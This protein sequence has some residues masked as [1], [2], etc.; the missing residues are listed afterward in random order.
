MLTINKHIKIQDDRLVGG[1]SPVLEIINEVENST[2]NEIIID[3]GGTGFVSPLFVLP[4]MV[5]VNGSSKDISYRNITGYLNTIKF[6]NEYKPEQMRKSEFLAHMEGYSNKTYIPVVSFLASK[7]NDDQK[8]AI[9]S[10]LEE[11][12]I[13]QLHLD[14]NIVT[15]LKYLIGE[16]VDNVTEHSESERGYIF[17]QAYPNKGYLDICIADNGITLLGSYMKMPDNEIASDLEAMQAANRGIST[18]NLPDAEN[19]GYGIITSKNMLIDG[20]GGNFIMI[21]GEAIHIK[22]R[23]IDKFV[24]LPQNIHWKGTIIALRIPYNNKSFNYIKYLE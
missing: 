7:N 22:N 13:R 20:L 23:E 12:I 4:L 3:F 8:S 24:I 19:R 10:T 21:S 14:R 18:K 16:T 17:A 9:I 5:Y 15:G 1:L 6:G 2:D 11:I